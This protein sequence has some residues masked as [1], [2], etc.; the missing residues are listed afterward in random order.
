MERQTKNKLPTS[1][2][3]AHILNAVG[4]SYLM[5]AAAMSFGLRQQEWLGEGCPFPGDSCPSLM[6]FNDTEEVV[7]KNC[8]YGTQNALYI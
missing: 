4:V 6:F 7:Y 1:V 3:G 8:S 5:S 2:I